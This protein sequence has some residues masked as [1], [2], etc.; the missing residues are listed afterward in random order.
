MKIRGSVSKIGNAEQHVV[1]DGNGTHC[2]KA[3]GINGPWSPACTTGIAL[4][5]GK[6]TESEKVDVLHIEA[7]GKMVKMLCAPYVD[8]QNP[9]KLLDALDTNMIILNA[10]L[11]DGADSVSPI[12]MAKLIDNPETVLVIYGKVSPAFAALQQF[13]GHLGLLRRITGMRKCKC[14]T[15]YRVTG[16][17]GIQV[18]GL[19]LVAGVKIKKNVCTTLLDFEA[20]HSP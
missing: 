17:G 10:N 4:D 16:K 18:Q 13:W 20:S 8:Q 15:G 9:L 14:V 6:S 3:L 11:A 5:G 1:V 7:S 19:V 12:V 2:S